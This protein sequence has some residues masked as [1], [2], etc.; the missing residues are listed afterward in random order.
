MGRPRALDRVANMASRIRIFDRNGTLMYEPSAPAFREWIINDIGSAQF[1]I[2]ARGMEPYIQPGNY[3]TIEHSKLDTWV[4][5]LNLPLTWG[6][7]TITVNAKSAMWLFSQRVGSYAEAVDGSWGE[8][9]MKMVSIVNAAEPT[10]VQMG[11]YE[12]GIS[13]SSVVDMS[14]VYTYLQR[15]LAQSQT[16]LDFRPVISNGRLRIFMDMKPYLYAPSNL[17]LEEGLNIKNNSP[18]LVTQGEIYND[19]T[20]LGIGLDQVKFQARA[21]D[22]ASVS[23]Y[24][25]RQKLFSEGQSQS[26]VDRL[27]TVRLAQYAYPRDTL[28]LITIDNAGATGNADTFRHTRVGNIG[29]VTLKSVGYRNGGLG[30][31][32]ET[33]IKVIQ[34]DDKTKE[35]T[36]VGQEI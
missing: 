22:E 2:K 19:I 33:Y 13:Y 26:D 1:T 15:A 9:L 28:A 12:D 3:I 32:G 8:V 17:V 21:T 31:K 18:V 11:E 36:L 10:L 27:A 29:K 35:A 16:R 6:A 30:Y 20:V 24:G 4:G 14:N 7:K 34:F 25:R 23:L 5:V